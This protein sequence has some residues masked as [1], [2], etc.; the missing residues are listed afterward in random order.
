M[1]IALGRRPLAAHT[2]LIA[3]LSRE[4]VQPTARVVTDANGN[5]STEW[6]IRGRRYNLVVMGDGVVALA[7]RAVNG[8]CEWAGQATL[9]LKEL[10][11]NLR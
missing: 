5:V 10:P 9:D 1:R 2:V 4:Y 3:D 7:G 6:L 11:Q 8:I